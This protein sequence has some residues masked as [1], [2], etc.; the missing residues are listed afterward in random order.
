M[1]RAFRF[2]LA[3]VARVREL[4][5]ET[6]RAELSAALGELHKAEDR[7]ALW[8]AELHAGRALLA[9]AQVAG[10]LDA[11][12][13]LARQQALETIEASIRF[14]EEERLRLAGLAEEARAAWQ[15]RRAD[16]EALARLSERHRERHEAELARLEAAELDEVGSQ[17]FA[18][19]A[20]GARPHGT[21]RPAGPSISCSSPGPLPADRP[22][23]GSP[24]LP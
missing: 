3:R 1:K 12:T 4:L 2:R 5:E 17:R 23:A 16:K 13:H 8:T 15:E 9:T 24:L 22:P 14:A 7:V 19:R 11:A 21:D 20:A 18:R 6:A 10:S